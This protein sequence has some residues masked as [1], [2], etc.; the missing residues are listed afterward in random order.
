MIIKVPFKKL[1]INS[2]FDFGGDFYI[3]T[4]KNKAKI[5]SPK[6]STLIDFLFEGKEVVE[7]DST[8]IKKWWQF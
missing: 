4:E 7:C 8:R 6:S 2:M 1:K 5:V 3:K